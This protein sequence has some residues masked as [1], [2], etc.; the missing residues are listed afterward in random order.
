MH[1]SLSGGLA[2]CGKEARIA[3]VIPQTFEAA[4]QRAQLQW[5]VNPEPGSATDR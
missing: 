2:A 4:D 5:M 1:H 3:L